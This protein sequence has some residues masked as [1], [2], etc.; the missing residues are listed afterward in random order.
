MLT[1]VS[2]N[3]MHDRDFLGITYLF[4]SSRHDPPV[5]EGKDGRA[6]PT[7]GLAA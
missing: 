4:A 2:I 1:I 5:P 7:T 6:P 3:N